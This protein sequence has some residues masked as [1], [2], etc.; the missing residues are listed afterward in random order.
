MKQKTKKTRGVSRRDFLKGLGGAVVGT[1]VIS[2]GHFDL[3]RAGQPTAAIDI[4]G[5]LQESPHFNKIK[6][7]LQTILKELKTAKTGARRVVS[8]LNRSS[9]DQASPVF[10][11]VLEDDEIIKKRRQDGVPAGDVGKLRFKD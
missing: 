4:P 1:G 11:G 9:T 5:G 7:F 10:V 8:R 2:T 3:G 6:E